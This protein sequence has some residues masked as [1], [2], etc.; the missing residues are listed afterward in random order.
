MS[1]TVPEGERWTNTDFGVVTQLSTQKSK[2]STTP[3]H[4]ALEY[5]HTLGQHTWCFMK[6]TKKAGG[7]N[8]ASEKSWMVK[9]EED[10]GSRKLERDRG[11]SYSTS[12]KDSMRKRDSDSN[13]G[14]WKHSQATLK[15]LVEAET[16]EG[17]LSAEQEER[18]SKSQNTQPAKPLEL[19]LHIKKLHRAFLSRNDS[20]VKIR[21][22]RI[23]LSTALKT[24]GPILP[25]LLFSVHQL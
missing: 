1:M 7:S 25:P 11:L 20:N 6:A 9:A 5:I 18:S 2:Q 24:L 14:W 17:P 12:T 13:T 8:G 3:W 15:S 21:P 22:S 16:W 19:A 23:F 10:A 4:K